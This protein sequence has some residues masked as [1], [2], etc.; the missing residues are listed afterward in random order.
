MNRRLRALLRVALSYYVTNGVT[1]AL[2]LL[3][4]SGAV[5]LWLG[6]VAAAA[7]GV[8]VIVTSPPD[9]P[10]PRR[11]KLRQMLPAPLLGVP[12]FAGVQ[13]LGSDPL[14]LGLLLVPA[15][16]VAFLF[17]AWGKRGIPIA[18]A[19]MFS[20]IFSMAVPADDDLRSVLRTTGHFALGALA[21]VVWS[22]TMNALLNSRYRVQH[23]ADT[24]HGVAALMRAQSR[25]AV[26]DAN[27]PPDAATGRLLALHA[28]LADQLQSARDLVLESPGTPRRQQLAGL[29]LLALELRDH[30]VAVEL[31]A[32]L[33]RRHPGHP[34]V[35]AEINAVLLALAAQVDLLADEML[36]ARIPA[37]PADLRPRLAALRL[38]DTGATSPDAVPL[39]G[40]PT[41]EAL[42]QG[43]A[44]RAGHIN[45]EVQRLA[46]LARG[47]A[48]PDLAVVRANWQMFVSPAAWS[49][50]PFLALWRW[51]AP[52]LRHAIRAAL[53]IAAGYIVSLVLPWKAHPY[54]ILITIVVVLRGSLAQ[55]VERRNHRVAGTLLGCVLAVG[56]LA[57]HL[58]HAALLWAMTAAQAV[59]HGFA[60]RRYLITAVAATVLGLVQAHLLNTGVS[61]S[62]ALVERIADTL[63]GAGIAWAFSYVLPS[64]ERGQI[65]ALVQ[66]TLAAQARHA[67]EALALG[68]IEA[69]DNTPELQWRLARREAYDSLSALVQA[70]QRS[71][72]EPRAAR[73]PL[74]PLERLQ[75]RCYQLLAQLSAVKSILLLRRGHIHAE[76]VRDPL[77]QAAER[78]DAM[79][80]GAPAAAGVAVAEAPPLAAVVAVAAVAVT[81]QAAEV[82]GAGPVPLPDPFESN[83]TPWL[84]RRLQ[85]A[86]TISGQLGDDARAALAAP[87]ATPM[88]RG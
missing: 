10:S 1:V 57:A 24:L 33:V 32:D 54:W 51:D 43:L 52:P 20:M 76:R 35:L 45:D 28:A 49:I 44:D 17:M 80:L 55:T 73:P 38:A 31:D 71:L 27:A 48:P 83:L 16:F 56:L 36:L 14:H 9:L 66:R 61:A 68:Q 23:I 50:R 81:G 64:W 82:Q 58:S 78:I 46:R 19:V 85:L 60:I 70:T 87:G 22:V 88:G 3:V 40:E 4:I 39:P 72:S 47:E 34:A 12:L 21:Y 59:A 86:E 79:L 77:R 75:A 63:L 41:P 30:L 29:L 7:A 15:T 65:P 74:E 84:L 13:L 69:V 53:A 8:G 6:A 26:G 11:A 25:R 18:I 2:G 62:L 37:L 5:H 67:R 42:L